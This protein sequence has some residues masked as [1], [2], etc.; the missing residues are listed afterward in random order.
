MNK[1][2]L[3]VEDFRNV[4]RRTQEVV[5]DS[6]EMLASMKEELMGSG[7]D[8]RVFDR[9]IVSMKK[10]ISLN[11]DTLWAGWSVTGNILYPPGHEDYVR[12]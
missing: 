9:A 5:K 8:V 1:E 10:I 6:P 2:D 3:T 12:S 7:E 4:V 11:V